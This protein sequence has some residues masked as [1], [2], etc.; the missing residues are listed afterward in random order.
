MA[1]QEKIK[2][3]ESRI[4]ALEQE[5]ET[6]KAMWKKTNFWYEITHTF[7]FKPIH[8]LLRVYLSSNPTL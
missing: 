2:F 7:M 6:L 8:T 1:A 3:L 5:N 4:T